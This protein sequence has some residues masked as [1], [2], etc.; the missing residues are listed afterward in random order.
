[1]K[2]K[3]YGIF[4]FQFLDNIIEKKRFEMLQILKKKNT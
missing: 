1:M 4:N 2:N 3:N